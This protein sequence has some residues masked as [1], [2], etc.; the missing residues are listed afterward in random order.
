MRPLK[1]QSLLPLIFI[2]LVFRLSAQTI[3][4]IIVADVEDAT[5]GVAAEQDMKQMVKLLQEVASAINYQFVHHLI[6]PHY[7]LLMG[8]RYDV[9]KITSLILGLD[10]RDEDIFFFYYS[11]HGSPS[12]NENDP[13][14]R[15][16]IVDY[17]HKYL[18]LGMVQKLIQI[19][20]P[21]LSIVMGN[22][23]NGSWN[24]PDHPFTKPSQWGSL[25]EQGNTTNQNLKALFMDYKGQITATSSERGLLSYAQTRGLDKDY[26][27]GIFTIL[28]YNSLVAEVQQPEKPSWNHIFTNATHALQ[29][30]SNRKPYYEI[31]LIGKK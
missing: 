7:S 15:P 3:H 21:R 20:E 16:H 19:S 5:I 14:A 2:L 31:N 17:E 18:S 29:A 27:G 12:F 23:C 6:T 1:L 28:F 11:G 30:R 26:H 9:P 13:F 25:F 10:I 4:A 24:N 8:R 22:L